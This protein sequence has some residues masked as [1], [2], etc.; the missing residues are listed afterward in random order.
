MSLALSCAGGDRLVRTDRGTWREGR[1]FTK[2]PGLRECVCGSLITLITAAA[3][4]GGYDYTCDSP[5]WD[6]VIT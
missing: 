3:E 1:G 2:S 4:V 5:M 6:K